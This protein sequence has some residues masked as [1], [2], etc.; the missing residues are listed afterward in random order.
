MKASLIPTYHFQKILLPCLLA[1]FAQ[2]ACAEASIWDKPTPPLTG[3]K[4]MTVYRSPTCGCCEKWVA[5]MQ[6]H[7]FTINEIQSEDMNEIKQKLGIQAPLQSCHTAVIGDYVIEGHVPAA[8]VKKL[9]KTKPKAAGLAAPG[10]PASSPGM[11]MGN[12]KPNFS[13][14]LFDKQ[15]HAN[16]FSEYSNH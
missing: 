15:G 7:G 11:E 4:E 12:I 10:M 14:L 8:D 2:T 9:L 16:Q 1:V 3:P 6:K 13:V 5:H